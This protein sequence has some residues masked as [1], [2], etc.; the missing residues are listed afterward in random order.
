MFAVGLVL[1]IVASALCG[2][3]TSPDMLTLSRALQGIG[4]AA[5]F[6]TGLALIA[7][8][9]PPASRPITKSGAF[10]STTSTR[11]PATSPSEAA[12]SFES[13][14]NSANLST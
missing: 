12:R 14:S 3:A 13:A 4:G 1:F 11:W 6:T 10:G 7:S 2:F 5:M 9:F 8:A